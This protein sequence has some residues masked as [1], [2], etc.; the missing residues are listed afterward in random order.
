MLY[1]RALLWFVPLLITLHNLEEILGMPALLADLP[2][3][4][5]GWV[6][7]LFPPGVFPPSRRQFL[8]MLLVVTVLPYLFALFPGAGRARG[9]RTTLLA[10]TQAVMLVNVFSHVFSA[11]F[12]RGYV[13][14]LG[15][16]LVCNLPFSL[17]FFRQGLK[18]G[19]LRDS[20]LGPLALAALLFHSAGLLGLTLLASPVAAV[21][22]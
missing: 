10:G 15:T 21:I 1:R 16:A 3:R 18:T 17:Y 7:N 2:N 14:G 4:L 6:L 20:D 5:P 22:P 8:V 12:V 11:L 19:W 13:P 9:L